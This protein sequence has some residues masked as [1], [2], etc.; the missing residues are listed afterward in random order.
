MIRAIV[1]T[2]LVALAAG[3]DGW[4]L[5]GLS[6]GSG[7]IVHFGALRIGA[8]ALVA[9]AVA[10]A[11]RESIRGGVIELVL[12]A[13]APLAGPLA[14]GL[15]LLV[16][17]TTRTLWRLPLEEFLRSV[18]EGGLSGARI[19]PAQFRILEP[20]ASI[21]S[22]PELLALRDLQA[23]EESLVHLARDQAIPDLELMKALLDHALPE[24]RL[25]AHLVL[26]EFQDRAIQELAE[27]RK[28]S[29][30]NPDESA[31]RKKA[32]RACILL[33]R[34][35]GE[36]ETSGRFVDEALEWLRTAHERDPEDR[37]V[38]AELGSLALRRDE[39]D[40]A[41]QYFQRLVA[42]DPDDLRGYLG[43]AECLLRLGDRPGLESACQAILDRASQDS[44][45]AEAAHYLR[46]GARGESA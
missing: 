26:L 20:K 42:G 19:N 44:E 32:G 2:A 38:L 21:P 41:R 24:V 28:E 16:S 23:V 36:P 13:A 4:A 9:L 11:R 8:I 14:A 37:Q 22:A 31:P 25:R 45:E 1:S 10:L 30:E 5:L 15:L 18:R 35:A 17:R 46:A 43:E 34:I 3:L 39:L 40:D 7:S 6:G 27:S 12:A 29:W 33:G